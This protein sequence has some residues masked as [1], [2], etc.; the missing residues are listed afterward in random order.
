MSGDFDYSNPFIVATDSKILK[1]VSLVDP[2]YPLIMNVSTVMK[3]RTKHNL[4]LYSISN[5]GEYLK[6]SLFAFESLTKGTSIV[7]VLD[8]YEPISGLLYIMILRY[9]KTIG[10]VS[11]NEITSFYEKERFERFVERTFN[12]DKKF[13]KNKEV[14]NKKHIQSLNRLQLP[15]NL[16]Y[17][18][19][20]NYDK[21]SFTISQVEAD[22]VA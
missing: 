19:S 10:S 16:A 11:V 22:I 3:L 14:I 5:S 15:K 13:F 21:A 1:Y 12:A 20:V 17:A 7:V 4:S 2:N 6:D 9:D 8:Q 18:L